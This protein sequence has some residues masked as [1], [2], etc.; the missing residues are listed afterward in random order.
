MG[1]A[2][3]E[4]HKGIQDFG[5]GNSQIMLESA[6]SLIRYGG[7]DLK[8]WL[9]LKSATQNDC[10]SLAI[11]FLALLPIILFY[12][13]DEYW[14]EKQLKMAMNHWPG[15]QF[16]ESELMV[17]GYLLRK[18]L[19]SETTINAL[20]K[21]QEKARKVDEQVG[22]NLA[23]IQRLIR[24]YVTLDTAIVQLN[25]NNHPESAAIYLA[26]YCFFCTPEQFQLSIQRAAQT[27]PQPYITKLIAAALSGA[28]NGQG[29]MPMTKRLV[30]SNQGFLNLEQNK[31]ITLADRLYATW[32][33]LYALDKHL[34][35]KPFSSLTMMV[36][37][38]HQLVPSS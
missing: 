5:Q 36:T 1:V 13:E 18:N 29:G 2:L 4:S 9:G 20:T 32:L 14:L 34:E 16:P 37:A 26:I 25:K 19:T 10:L 38:P 23:K 31:L 27:Q 3:A 22:E 11:G 28:Y 35:K 21:I 24:E 30:G 17:V 8:D 15:R 12:H 33:G 6:K 7:L